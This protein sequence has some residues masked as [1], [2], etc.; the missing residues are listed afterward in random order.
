[1]RS[2]LEICGGG[3]GDAA[4]NG[5][6]ITL[7]ARAVGT[8]G[9]SDAAS[10]KPSP[11]L[12]AWTS[13]LGGVTA[14]CA[15]G[16][17]THGVVAAIIGLL[18]VWLTR[19]RKAS[20]ITEERVELLDGVGLQLTRVSR[21]GRVRSRCVVELDE[22]ESVFIHEGVHLCRVIA[23]LAVSLRVPPQQHPAG[24]EN[25]NDVDMTLFPQRHV[26]LFKCLRLDLVSLQRAYS[27]VYDWLLQERVADSTDPSAASSS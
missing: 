25:G 11:M 6:R 10:R 20:E 19:M 12:D 5:R 2:R 18:L 22:L 3:G 26:L 13:A 27:C 14:L 7:V 8:G 1:M 24:Q 17:M 16:G 4:A 15:A 9:T 23:F 21:D